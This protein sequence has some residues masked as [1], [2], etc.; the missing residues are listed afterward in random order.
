M[1]HFANVGVLKFEVVPHNKHQEDGIT[2]FHRVNKT[3]ERK[4]F[5]LIKSEHVCWR[6]YNIHEKAHGCNIS[7]ISS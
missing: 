1:L 3:N 7:P 2:D 4:Y 5:T 6:I